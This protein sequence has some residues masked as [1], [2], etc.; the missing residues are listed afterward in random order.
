LAT[1][2]GIVVLSE[3][4]FGL[5]IVAFV[6][7]RLGQEGISDD[8]LALYI[9][10]AV[11]RGLNRKSLRDAIRIARKS[12]TYEDVNETVRTLKKYRND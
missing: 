7:S 12:K 6:V 2:S 4:E 3:G 5:A 1:P 9:A 8:N 10:N 11:L